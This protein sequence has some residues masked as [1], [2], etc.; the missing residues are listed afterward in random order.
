MLYL[1]PEPDAIFRDI[2][3]RLSKMYP[4]C[5]PYGGL[6]DDPKPH[7]TVVESGDE[8]VLDQ[9]DMDLSRRLPLAGRAREA[10][11]LLEGSEDGGVSTRDCCSVTVTPEPPACAS[12]ELPGLWLNRRP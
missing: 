7:V 3:L 9:A 10:W 5:P 6:Y 12:L 11:L 2:T 8:A 1:S 4:D